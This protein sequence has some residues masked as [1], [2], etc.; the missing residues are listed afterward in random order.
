[1]Q[2]EQIEKRISILTPEPFSALIFDCDGT[3]ADTMPLHYEVWKQ[4]L[5][6]RG[7]EIS[8]KQFYGFAGTPT[9]EIIQ[10]LNE[11]HGYNLNGREIED[12]KEHLYAQIAHQ[13]Q[14]IEAV[15][16]I[17]RDQFGKVPMAV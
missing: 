12:E 6:L 10:I 8:T 2:V 17:A 15:A 9:L 14:E 13:I 5:A 16:N 4:V 1:M 3:L 11:R 7:I